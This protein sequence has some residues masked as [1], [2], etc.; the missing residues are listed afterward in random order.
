MKI[1]CNGILH[2]SINWQLTLAEQAIWIKLIAYSEVSGGPPGMISDNDS[3][4]IPKEYLA[5]EFHCDIETLNSCMDKCIED[6]RISDNSRGIQIINFEAYQF[7]EYDRQKPYRQ[8][9]KLDEIDPDKFV[10]GKY[11][12]MVKR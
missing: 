5:H 8:A 3:K 2:G 12:K 11:G 7:S 10:K 9:K 1:D 4:P 6:G